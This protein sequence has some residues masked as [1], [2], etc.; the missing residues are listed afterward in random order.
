MC[1]GCTAGHLSPT[2]KAV[3]LIPQQNLRRSKCQDGHLGKTGGVQ[4]LSGLIGFP[5]P[6]EHAFLLR[7]VSSSVPRDSSAAAFRYPPSFVGGWQNPVPMPQ[8][9]AEPTDGQFKFGFG[10]EAAAT[11]HLLRATT[12]VNFKKICPDLE[13]HGSCTSAGAMFSSM[14]RALHGALRKTGELPDKPKAR[15][16]CAAYELAPKVGRPRR[17]VAAREEAEKIAAAEDAERRRKLLL[18]ENG[19]GMCLRPSVSMPDATL[20]DS[21]HVETVCS[22][23]A[24]PPLLRCARLPRLDSVA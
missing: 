7:D 2:Q 23:P 13:Q 8:T 24:L 20:A 4:A 3:F 21:R 14:H 15:D 17:E 22:R 18:H 11:V 19:R 16:F 6:F 5:G 10:E 1:A 9:K 12:P